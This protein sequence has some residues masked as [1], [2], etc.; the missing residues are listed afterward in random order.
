MPQVFSAVLRV[1]RACGGFF[2]RFA[3]K[4]RT[5]NPGGISCSVGHG[6]LRVPGYGERGWVKDMDYIVLEGTTLSSSAGAGAIRST[7][8]TG[9]PPGAGTPA[10]GTTVR[11]YR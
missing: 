5:E 1:A 3:S 10:S 9:K 7:A 11:R 4:R 2:K 6:A 8:S